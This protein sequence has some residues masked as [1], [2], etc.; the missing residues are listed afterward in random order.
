MLT[1]A[2]G[3]TDAQ[4][5]ARPDAFPCVGA[6]YA[7]VKATEG[8]TGYG[9]PQRRHRSPY[10]GKGGVDAWRRGSRARD[11]ARRRRRSDRFSFHLACFEIA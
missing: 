4:R 2:R 3:R 1:A 8:P 11:A 7:G 9:G 10:A 5:V 6:A